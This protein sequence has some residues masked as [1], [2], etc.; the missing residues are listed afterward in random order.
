M[1]CKHVIKPRYID[2]ILDG[3]IGNTNRIDST[4]SSS[5]FLVERC[6]WIENWVI[7]KQLLLS[8]HSISIDPKFIAFA[9]NSNEYYRN[10]NYCQFRSEI[11]IVMLIRS[12]ELFFRI[13]SV[14]IELI[15]W[16]INEHEWK[17]VDGI[18]FFYETLENHVLSRR[19]RTFTR[20]SPSSV[21]IAFK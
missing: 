3:S 2:Y 7:H 16:P 1:S 8:S 15:D 12:N 5:V 20:Y 4:V 6:T 9:V 13:W 14:I 11:E 10:S 19:I 17:I 18:T 21:H